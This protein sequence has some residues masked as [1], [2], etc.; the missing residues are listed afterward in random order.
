LEVVWKYNFQT[1]CN[2]HSMDIV[3]E[4]VWICYGF[5][6]YSHGNSMDMLWIL[7]CNCKFHSM[8]FTIFSVISSTNSAFIKRG[9]GNFKKLCNLSPRPPVEFPWL[10]W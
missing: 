2:F 1:C 5:Y 6:G 10:S 8:D 4:I 9:C 7:W 3:M